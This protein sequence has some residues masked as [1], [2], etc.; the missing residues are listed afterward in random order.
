VH[1]LWNGGS[2][3]HFSNCHSFSRNWEVCFVIL[4]LLGWTV[5]GI[6]NNKTAMCLDDHFDRCVDVCVH[7]RVKS[8][9]RMTAMTE[10]LPS[11]LCDN[12]H[13][14]VTQYYI[15]I[16]RLCGLVVRVPGYRSRG[17]G[18]IPGATRFSTGSTTGE[19]LEIRSSSSSLENRDY[20]HRGFA[21][22]TTWYPSIRKSWHLLRRR[23][24][25]IQAV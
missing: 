8:G 5:C 11:L 2:K 20:G 1:V 13:G 25:V 23:V 15:G 10:S 3:S 7:I 6:F 24:A 18:L 16:D 9:W 19:L 17:P 4:A 21:V 12:I 14:V 22:L